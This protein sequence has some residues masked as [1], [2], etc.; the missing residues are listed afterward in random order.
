LY[1]DLFCIGPIDGQLTIL[2]INDNLY[3]AVDFMNLPPLH[4]Q[5][6]IGDKCVDLR[7]LL[8]SLLFVCIALHVL[9]GI[10]FLF[11][12]KANVAGGGGESEE[13][14]ESAV[15]LSCEAV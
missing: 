6:S 13:T 9:C 2:T 15:E 4:A 11:D 7:E 12:R 3:E 1:I 14:R 10:S 5:S 8:C